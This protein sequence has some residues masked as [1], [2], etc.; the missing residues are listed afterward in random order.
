[1]RPV[2]LKFLER[3]RGETDRNFKFAA[4]VPHNQKPVVRFEYSHRS[5]AAILRMLESKDQGQTFR[6]WWGL[7][8]DIRLTELAVRREANVKSTPLVRCLDAKRV[9]GRGEDRFLPLVAAG[10]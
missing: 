2:N 8:F 5:P 10:Q 6:F 1:M 4:L 9:A 7:G 3:T